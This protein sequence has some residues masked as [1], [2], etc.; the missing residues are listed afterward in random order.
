M[1][2]IY[3]ETIDVT[4]GKRLNPGCQ[5]GLREDGQQVDLS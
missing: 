1:L 4:S 3:F 2:T 5:M